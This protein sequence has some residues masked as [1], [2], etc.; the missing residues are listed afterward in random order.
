MHETDE[1]GHIIAHALGGSDELDNLVP[2]DKNLNHSAWSKIEKRW[3]K[4]LN[5]PDVESVDVDIIMSYDNPK[6]PLRPTGFAVKYS[7]SRK[8]GRKAIAKLIKLNNEPGQS[9]E[10]V[11]VEV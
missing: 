7:V 2:M 11:E 5:D 1:G 9:V 3:H 6:A 10:L 8:N 4:L